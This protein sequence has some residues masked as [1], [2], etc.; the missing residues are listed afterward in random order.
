MLYSDE[1]TEAEAEALADEQERL[2]EAF[3]LGIVNQYE[4]YTEKGLHRS[5]TEAALN[6]AGIPAVTVGLGGH[7]VV[8]DDVVAAGVAGCARVMA[9]MGMLE[10]VPTGVTAADP[11]YGSPVPYPV[12]LADGPYS[13][14]A[15]IVRHR[16]D[17]GETVRAG[18]P[19]ADVVDVHGRSK[20]T[21]DV[22]RDGYLISPTE[23][24]A[25]YENE[26]VASLAVRDEG[27]VVVPRE[28]R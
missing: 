25:V 26:S 10:A 28:P 4:G 20:A 18:D 24:I 17:P 15:G 13:P 22:E 3:G 7:S 27:E 11:G 1:R 19:I 14:T 2:M 8:D 6:L 12:R 23:G 21:V 5:T 16:V 9:E